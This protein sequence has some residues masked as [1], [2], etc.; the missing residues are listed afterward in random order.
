MS[1]HLF[2]AVFVRMTI[3]W[4][5]K[6][7][8]DLPGHSHMESPNFFS[9]WN[10]LVGGQ[11]KTIV[12]GVSQLHS[13]TERGCTYKGWHGGIY[14]LYGIPASPRVQSRVPPLAG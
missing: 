1:K 13:I 12:A 2:E 6:L 3:L 7:L 14:D 8:D 11:D 4:H 5:N 10:Y 9:I